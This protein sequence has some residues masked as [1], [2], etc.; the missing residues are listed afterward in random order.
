VQDSIEPPR[1]YSAR[2]FDGKEMGVRAA[3]SLDR[4]ENGLLLIAPRFFPQLP[5]TI[6]QHIRH[7]LGKTGERAVRMFTY[8]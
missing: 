7:H 3:V 4:F 5:R 8:R 1:R 6:R 2:R